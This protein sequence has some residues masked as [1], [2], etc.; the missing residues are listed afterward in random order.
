MS[1]AGVCRNADGH[2][3]GACKF[4]LLRVGNTQMGRSRYRLFGRSANNTSRK[5]SHFSMIFRK[6]AP[7]SGGMRL[8]RKLIRNLAILLKG[9][10]MTE[11]AE[12]LHRKD[13]SPTRMPTWMPSRMPRQLFG[14]V[15]SQQAELS[16]KNK[17]ITQESVRLAGHGWLCESICLESPGGYPKGCPG[18]YAVG[19]PAGSQ[20][21]VS[22]L[23]DD[24]YR[25]V[26]QKDAQKGTPDG[27]QSLALTDA[28]RDALTDTQTG[29]T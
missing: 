14:R 19:C 13:W 5:G 18:G 22:V 9:T 15:T 16:N 7:S 10:T 24:L 2:L 23:S 11:E 29:H 25:Q 8:G 26:A 20:F 6:E 27:L 1:F 4:G 3:H 17:K 21:A 28:Q 12:E